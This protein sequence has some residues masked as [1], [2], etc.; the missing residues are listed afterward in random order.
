MKKMGKIIENKNMS[1]EDLNKY[2]IGRHLDDIDDEYEEMNATK[3]P[4]DI[5]QDMIYDAM[6]LPNGKARKAMIEAA[7]KIYPHLADAWIILAEET[8]TTQEEELE[9]YKKAVEAGEADLGKQFFKENEGHFWGITESR[10]YMRAKIYLAQA[11]W[12]LGSEDKAISHYKDCLR[13]NPNDNQGVRD[14]LTAWLLIKNDLAGVEAIQ[15]QYKENFSTQYGYSRALLLFKKLGPGSKRTSTQLDKAIECNQFVPQYLLGKT[16]MPKQ[17]PGS[18]SMGSKEEAV[19][20][21]D[22]ALRAWKETPGA[23]SWLLQH[24]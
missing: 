10:P 16:K 3:S 11:L 17:I 7:L 6:D 2:F 14:I 4:Q 23:L 1:I 13:L 8:A 20:Y 5:A 19:I 24:C 12:N 18:Y 15:K 9:Y 21:T 22:Y